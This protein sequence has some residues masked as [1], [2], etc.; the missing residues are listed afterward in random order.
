[1]FINMLKRVITIALVLIG[2]SLFFTHNPIK[3]QPFVLNQTSV[4]EKRPHV[5]VNRQTRVSENSIANV[6][7]I[8]TSNPI[9]NR[10]IQDYIE[11]HYHLFEMSCDQLNPLLDLN[12]HQH[13][14]TIN[15]EVHQLDQSTLSVVF[16]HKL[17]KH[18][19]IKYRNTDNFIVFLKD[20]RLVR[21]EI[22]FDKSK[23]ATSFYDQVKRQ[24]PFNEFSNDM[25][26]I[27]S[28]VNEA[29]IVILKNDVQLVFRSNTSNV[30]EDNNINIKHYHALAAINPAL[31][32]ILNIQYPS[33]NTI[34]SG[35]QNNDGPKRI[36]L[37][38][39]DGPS[40]Y[41]SAIMATLEKYNAKA[42][43]FVLGTRVEMYPDLVKQLHD[44]GHEIA[45]HSYN[46]KRLT[47]LNNNDILFQINHTNNLIMNV[48][49]VEPT[50]LRAPYGIA[51]DRVK[52]LTTMRFVN[53]NIDSLDWKYRNAS[54]IIHRVRSGARNNG[55]V[56]MHDLYASTLNSLDPLLASLSAQGYEFVTVSEL[57]GY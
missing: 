40:I 14:L 45:N 2:L 32:S 1:M 30:T 24:L 31:V 6:D 23:L 57:M 34:Y 16:T 20:N 21:S 56:L 42:T 43:F 3:A 5:Q 49:G 41:T 35:P 52:S 18:Q 9:I 11:Y 27:K 50:L 12:A 37:T 44:Q 28:M 38:F 48:I 46:H 47:T 55:I 4:Q 25:E 53:W 54:N 7:T 13:E 15:A 8:I 33:T 39:D 19:T 17:K 36:A 22:L 26:H 29:R 10:R 51:D